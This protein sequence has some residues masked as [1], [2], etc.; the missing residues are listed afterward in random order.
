MMLFQLLWIAASVVS[1]ETAREMS[2]LG[3]NA[4]AL[5]ALPA[6]A[7]L[8]E[9]A[10]LAGAVVF[11]AWADGVSTSTAAMVAGSVSQSAVRTE[12]YPANGKRA[13]V[14]WAM[15]F[16]REDNDAGAAR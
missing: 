13:N 10:E 11:W 8:A 2:A 7:A 3:L 4:A 6:P 15:E 12:K 9:F 16:S 14:G 1:R 5:A